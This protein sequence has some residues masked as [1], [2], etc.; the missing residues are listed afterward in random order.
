MKNSIRDE[1]WLKSLN[2]RFMPKHV[3]AVWQGGIR[4]G[5]YYLTSCSVGAKGQRNLDTLQLMAGVLNSL[6]GPGR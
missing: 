2:E 1:A 3:A 6:K 4:I 5:S